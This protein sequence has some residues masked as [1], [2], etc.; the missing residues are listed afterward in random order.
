MLLQD[1]DSLH[2][3]LREHTTQSCLGFRVFVYSKLWM[4]C[5]RRQR[6]SYSNILP[7]TLVLCN[8]P[9]PF[10][11]AAHLLSQGRSKVY[12][13]LSFCL[14]V[15]DGCSV[16]WVTKSSCV[17][18]SVFVCVSWREHVQECVRACVNTF[19]ALC[20][21]VLQVGCVLN[22]LIFIFWWA[23]SPFNT[24]PPWL[25]ICCVPLS[26]LWQQK[27]VTFNYTRTKE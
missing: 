1:Q 22:C 5:G 8:S 21:A 25:R 16:L 27:A 13:G 12:V 14:T 6:T 20:V 26:P 15:R 3:A 23:R 2:L 18:D 17:V 24:Q 11:L 9:S 4:N 7:L 10:I 19:R